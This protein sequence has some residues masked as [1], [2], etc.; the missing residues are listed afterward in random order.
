MAEKKTVKAD[1]KI[2]A[3]ETAAKKTITVKAK[4]A[5][6]AKEVK[7]AVAPEVKPEAAKPATKKAAPKATKPAEAK[8]EVK[9]EAKKAEEVNVSK[10]KKIL[11]AASEVRPFAA[12]GGLGEVMGSLPGAINAAADGY[13]ARVIMPLYEAVSQEFRSQMKFLGYTYVPVA[14]RNQYCGVFELKHNGVTVYFL[15]NEYY[16]K[17]TSLYGYFDD[18]ERYA[19]FSRAIIETI[20][21]TG[22]KPDVIACNDWQT[23]LVPIYY[24]LFYM[25]S[26]LSGIKFS[27]TIHNIEY[28]GKFPSSSIED[29]FGI[30]YYE[31]KS[32]EFDNCINLM[33]GAIDYS[34]SVSTVSPTYAQEILHNHD[35]AHGLEK[36]L[37]ANSQKLRG[38]LNGIDVVGY[39]SATDKS[40]FKNFTAETLDAKKENKTALQSMLGLPV[41]ESVPM[42]AIISRLVGHKGMD[43][44]KGSIEELLK[45]NIQLVVLGLGESSYENYFKYLQSQYPTKVRAVLA[46]NAD[47]SRKFY[48]AADLFLMPS[49]SEPCG[50]S[51]MIAA[52][53]GTV[54]IVRET[55]GLF[56]SIHDCGD[57]KSVGNGFTFQAYDSAALLHA[58]D[59]AVHMYSDYPEVFKLIM[60]RAMATDFSWAVSAK[61]YIKLFAD[62]LA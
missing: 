50:L 39:N 52:Q 60:Q 54:S 36:V 42:I 1:T 53:Y 25:Y 4:P 16:F 14:W 30:P 49:R 40:I 45:Q 29:L 31:L 58:V 46:Y 37:Q 34:E 2:E 6:P 44:V 18:G 10:D 38:I 11:F 15:D 21:I 22:F 32:I 19:F 8:P 55:G 26:A 20:S 62:T 24:K 43:L 57:G 3:A 35:Y 12:S 41:D 27:F 61:E 51:Q 7:P 5:A 23:A 28:Q 48:G 17:R 13:E 59:R 56:D 33:K 9:Q 47:Y